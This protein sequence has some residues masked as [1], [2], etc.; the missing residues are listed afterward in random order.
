VGE[1]MTKI[2]FIKQ[3]NIA[4]LDDKHKKRI[5]IYTKIWSFPFAHGL[6]II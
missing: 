5:G 2:K 3:Q 6:L 1:T 4:Y